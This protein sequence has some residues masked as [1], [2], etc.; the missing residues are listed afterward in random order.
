MWRQAREAR[1][2]AVLIKPI[3]PSSLYDTL[4]RV[5]HQE[6]GAVAVVPM[7]EMEAEIELRKQHAGQRVLLVED[8]PINQEVASELLGSSTPYEPVRGHRNRGL[9]AA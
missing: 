1:F 3:T 4:V 8:N 6:G 2:D 7:Q 9:E 5:L